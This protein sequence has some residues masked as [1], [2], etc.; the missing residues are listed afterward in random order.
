LAPASPFTRRRKNASLTRP[1]AYLT[2]EQRL[3]IDNASE[4]QGASD[5]SIERVIMI[6]EDMINR[7]VG[8]EGE[9]DEE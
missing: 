8:E 6:S 4:E 1:T 2:D 9:A 5:Q 7:S 3:I